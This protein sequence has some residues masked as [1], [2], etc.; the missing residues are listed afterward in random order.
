M[1]RTKRSRVRPPPTPKGE[2]LKTT[3]ANKDRQIDVL[4]KRIEDL[5]EKV[6]AL[7]IERDAIKQN[8]TQ[9][10]D[11]KDGMIRRL[12]EAK[13]LSEYQRGYIDRVRE[14]D[15]RRHGETIPE[16]MIDHAASHRL[17][18]ALQTGA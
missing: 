11:G 10:I 1:P 8:R 13:E 2:I 3:L 12:E 7:T 18:K 14:E 17:H 5:S 15:R 16:N 6:G 9:L 4:L